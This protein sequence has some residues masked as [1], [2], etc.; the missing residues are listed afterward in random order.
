MAFME[1]SIVPIG[2]GGTSLSGY[3]AETLKILKI[4]GL[5]FELHDMGTTVTG[6]P[7]D[8]FRVANEM[9][10]AAFSM[11][12]MRIYTVIKIDDRRDKTVSSLGHKTHSALEKIKN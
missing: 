12:V 11:G 3:V 2:T 9:H 1:I 10:N 6:E 5:E 4:S 8:L 7:A